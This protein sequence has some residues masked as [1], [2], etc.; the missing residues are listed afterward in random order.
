MKLADLKDMVRY[1]HETSFV[2]FDV[3]WGWHSLAKYV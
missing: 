1:N 2:V 3:S